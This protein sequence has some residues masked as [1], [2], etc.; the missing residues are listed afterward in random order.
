MK[1]TVFERD[2]SFLVESPIGGVATF[3][4]SIVAERLA[5]LIPVALGRGERVT[6][7]V[8]PCLAEE[9]KHG[10]RLADLDGGLV[11]KHPGALIFTSSNPK[12]AR[13]LTEIA[14]LCLKVVA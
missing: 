6:V 11:S 3:R 13:D 5:E 4:A 7:D 14:N 1:I 2:D 12:V 8:V 9:A 10:I